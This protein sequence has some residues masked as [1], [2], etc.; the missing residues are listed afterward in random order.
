M[1]TSGTRDARFR[2]WLARAATL[3]LAWSLSCGGDRGAT[4]GKRGEPAPSSGGTAVVCLPAAPA[5]LDPFVSPDLAST[6]LAPLLYTPLVRY[7]EGTSYRPYLAHGWRWSRDHRVLTFELRDDLRWSDGTP[8]TAADVAFTIR[9]A[10]DA[11]YGYPEAG[12]FSDVDTVEASGDSAVVVRFG[13]PFTPG[14]EPFT[15][16]LPILPAHLLGSLGPAAFSHA[17]YHHD[18]VGSGPYR[19]APRSADGSL[20]F[21]R[22]AD[23][24]PA[25]AAPRLERIVVRTIPES[26]TRA[27]EFRTGGVDACVIPA[28]QAPDIASIEG[29]R[30]LPV[31]PRLTQALILDTRQPPLRDVRVRRAISAALD[32]SELAAIVSPAA[33]PAR[34][35]I[36]PGHPY[37]APDA[38][39]PDDNLAM[40]DSLL[41]AA[42]WTAPREGATRVNAD[43]RGL[44][45]TV[46]TPPQFRQ[47]VVALQAQLGRAGFA[48]KP[49]IMEFASLIGA[50]QDPARRPP[51]V[52]L[53][54]AS[55]RRLRPD[56][57]T[58]LVTGGTTNASS[59]SNPTVDSAVARLESATDTAVVAA[60]Y[61]ILQERVALDVPVV[62]TIRVPHILAVGPRLRG[63]EVGPAGP[64]ASVASWWIPAADRR[65]TAADSGQGG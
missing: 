60:E 7:G 6:E 49:R 31:P 4:G 24:P 18:P 22:R 48:V 52:L 38:R 65:A 40:A 10:A 16:A 25:L 3:G 21:V 14:L 39:Q 17:A 53:G 30:L 28:S 5:S 42:G 54:F 20:T 57:Y 12:D 44:E 8:V 23:F 61:R 29:V 41:E 37:A 47:V 26:S 11:R 64:L 32:R 33:R 51:A 19:L 62:Y 58:S 34:G 50:L 46:A 55:D 59:Y 43:G 63:V 2:A 15:G 35:P 13:K 45:L 27:A 36:A 9:R 56:F 1:D